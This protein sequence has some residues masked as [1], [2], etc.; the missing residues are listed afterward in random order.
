MVLQAYQFASEGILRM[1]PFQIGAAAGSGGAPPAPDPAA[2]SI[3][4]MYA[5]V[6]CT[7]LDRR[8]RRLSLYRF[9]K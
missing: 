8:E 6:Y 9:Y 5:R 4:T 3:L 7:V 1:P 2:V